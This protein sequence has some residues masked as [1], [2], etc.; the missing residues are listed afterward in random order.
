[1]LQVASG[2]S[3]PSSGAHGPGFT[4]PA[5]TLTALGALWLQEGEDEPPTA[6]PNPAPVTS[7]DSAS[8]S[9]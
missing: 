2:P 4:P 3:G 5:I 1:M 8:R 6:Q 9:W 7:K